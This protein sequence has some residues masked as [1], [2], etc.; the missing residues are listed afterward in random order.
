[1]TGKTRKSPAFGRASYNCWLE[2]LSFKLDKSKNYYISKTSRNRK[3][4]TFSGF[5]VLFEN[6]M[7]YFLHSFYGQG[8]LKIMSINL[9]YRFW[10]IPRIPNSTNNVKLP[11][12]RHASSL[13]K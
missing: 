7:F 10:S 11:N 3:S 6:N 4:A 5:P 1:M 13:D 12:E 9:E 2:V 8:P